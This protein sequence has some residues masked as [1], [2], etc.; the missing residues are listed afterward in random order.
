MLW[1]GDEMANAR[2]EQIAAVVAAGAG[3]KVEIPD[4]RRRIAEFYAW[5]DSGTEVDMSDRARLHRILG[6]A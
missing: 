3:A 4:P 2:A 5:L 1:V 6:V